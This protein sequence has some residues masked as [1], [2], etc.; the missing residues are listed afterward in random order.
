MLKYIN[1]YKR[2]Q[3]REENY[4]FTEGQKRIHEQ[5]LKSQIQQQSTFSLPL[6]LSHSFHA[7]GIH[8]H[9]N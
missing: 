9:F 1:I 4:K 8:G 7:L 3:E 5:N 6:P 2:E